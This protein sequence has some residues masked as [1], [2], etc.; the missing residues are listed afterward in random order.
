MIRENLFIKRL[1]R[2]ALLIQFVCASC[3]ALLGY[4]FSIFFFV[5]TVFFIVMGYI[6]QVPVY[7][8]EKDLYEKAGFRNMD[9]LSCVGMLLLSIIYLIQDHYR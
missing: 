9:P 2:W 3:V 7:A 6:Y 5:S 1:L 8:P 4:S